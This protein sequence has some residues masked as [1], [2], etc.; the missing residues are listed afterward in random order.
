MIGKRFLKSV[1]KKAIN[2]G[3]EISQEAHDA[4]KFVGKNTVKVGEKLGEAAT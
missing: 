2:V 1:A 3:E 4:A